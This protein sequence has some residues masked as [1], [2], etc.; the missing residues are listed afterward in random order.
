M[1]S[2]PNAARRNRNST[3]T[4]TAS[5][6]LIAFTAYRVST[7]D[8]R[9][10][11]RKRRRAMNWINLQVS[12]I[13]APAYVGSTPT[14]RATWFN[15]LAYAVEHEN[16]G[17]LA[18]AATWKD[19]QWQQA[20]GV[21]AR[22]VRSASKLLTVEGDDVVVAFYPREKQREVQAK[23]IQAADA[24]RARWDNAPRNTKSDASRIAR[25]NAEGEGE[26]EGQSEQE[27]QPPPSAGVLPFPVGELASTAPSGP[28]AAPSRPRDALFEAL[29]RAEG[30]NPAELTK[31][32]ARAIAVALADIR[33]A[34]PNVTAS[35]IQNRAV[36]YRR[37][38]GTN[39]TLTAS[40]LAKHWAR[41]SGVPVAKTGSE[42]ARPEPAGW[43][44]WLAATM[45]ANEEAGPLSQL[46]AAKNNQSF[47][48]MPAS[49]Q[50]RCRAELEQPRERRRVSGSP[51][52][53]ELNRF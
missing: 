45:P 37:V 27:T 14:E 12:I 1:T 52:P 38:M 19:R 28:P 23:R 40:A 11:Q 46:T 53:T 32:A 13:R 50:A 35:E 26:R 17:R 51:L 48:M 2:H 3:P 5:R 33:R 15:V 49:W 4:I 22:E 39:C 30:S 25:R 29:A 43:L 47:T 18:G 44:E 7:T 16:D 24:A 6:R 36:I 21:T 42:P 31:S 8:L 41:C 20:C 9:R 34:T 10:R